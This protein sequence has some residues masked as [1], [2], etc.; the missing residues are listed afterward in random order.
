MLA[1]QKDDSIPVI[2]SPED[3]TGADGFLFGFLTRYGSMAA[4]MKSFFDS[5]VQLWKEQKLAQKTSRIFRQHRHSRRRPID[6]CVNCNYSTSRYIMLFV[7]I[8]Y[9]FGA[10]MFKM[11]SIRGGSPY[12]DEVYAGDG[13]RER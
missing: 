12:G 8:G 5:S 13:T 10:C 4:Q 6:H 11:D 7:L 1:P 3:L 2:G 9:T